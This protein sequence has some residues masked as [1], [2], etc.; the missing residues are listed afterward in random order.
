MAFMIDI[1]SSI[2]DHEINKKSEKKE[3]IEYARGV[4]MQ[5]EKNEKPLQRGNRY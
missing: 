2:E 5:K 1:Y 3:F 4:S